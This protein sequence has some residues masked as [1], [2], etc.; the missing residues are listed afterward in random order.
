[1]ERSK[2]QPHKCGK[3]CADHLPY[4]SIFFVIEAKCVERRTKTMI[5]VEEQECNTNQVKPCIVRIM[6]SIFYHLS[7]VMSG[8]FVGNTIWQKELVK[9]NHD[10]KENYRTCNTHITRKPA[11]PFVRSRYCILYGAGLCVVACYYYS[12]QHVYYN[13]SKK[14]NFDS[15]DQDIPHR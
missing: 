12:L 11:G 8:H 1:R 14:H 5:K 4:R 3:A 6:K 15:T 7:K 2:A 10:K 13:S 9:V